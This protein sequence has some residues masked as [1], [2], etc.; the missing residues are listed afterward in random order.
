MRDVRGI[1]T[2]WEH[3]AGPTEASEEGRT[4]AQR[5]FGNL[6]VGKCKTVEGHYIASWEMEGDHHTH[7]RGPERNQQA[8]DG[9]GG[10]RGGTHQRS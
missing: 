5:G 2:I 7:P 6:N 4:G 1:C 8:G 3:K 10:G 9:K